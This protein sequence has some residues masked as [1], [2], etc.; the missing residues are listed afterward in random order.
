MSSSSIILADSICSTICSSRS[1]APSK[2]WV[3]SVFFAVGIAKLEQLSIGAMDKKRDFCRN[4]GFYCGNFL[5]LCLEKPRGSALTI[6]SIPARVLHEN[7]L[8]PQQTEGLL[9]Q[10]P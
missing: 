2:F 5:E 1:I 3:G 10:R 4:R 8:P 6:G 9:R 7:Q